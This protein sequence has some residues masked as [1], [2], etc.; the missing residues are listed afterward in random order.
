MVHRRSHSEDCS[1]ATIG[2][3]ARCDGADCYEVDPH[4]AWCHL[5]CEA[6]KA[7]QNEYMRLLNNFFSAS[8]NDQSEAAQDMENRM[9][10]MYQQMIPQHQTALVVFLK[11]W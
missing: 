2:G 11:N 3:D 9:T 5:H 1:V 8:A 4:D 7:E 10:E 6:Y